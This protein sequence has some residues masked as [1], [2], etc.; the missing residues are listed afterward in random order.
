MNKLK[1]IKI[2]RFVLIIT[3]LVITIPNISSQ[4]TKNELSINGGVGLSAFIMQPTLENVLPN[5]IIGDIGFGLTF[6]L[7]PKWGI[8]LGAGIG[9]AQP[10]AKTNK[11]T[12]LNSGLTDS[13][14]YLF[15]LH[16]NLLYFTEQQSMSFLSVPLMLHY[17]AMPQ[18]RL[19]AQHRGRIN[20]FYA[21]TGIKFIIPQNSQYRSNTTSLTNAAYYPDMDNWAGTQ[22]FAGLGTFEGV[23]SEGDL[24]LDMFVAFSLEA[25]IK[26]I[27]NK[28]MFLYTGL[29]LDI[30]LEDPYQNRRL[31][32]TD[33]N[34]A[35][36][37]SETSFL[38]FSD[39]ITFTAVGLKLRLAFTS[40][41]KTQK[42][43]HWIY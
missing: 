35:V 43:D 36:L 11:I 5:G 15:D 27:I 29:F 26:S 39:K 7:H 21:M 24:E 8:Y 16:T 42:C 23:G 32:Y 31:S 1:K 33:Q 13:N 9:L 2:I 40:L 6:F 4:Q 38:N 12:I 41:K 30:G 3:A 19:S 10:V 22:T 17:Q 25:G 20:F 14:G 37:I 18:G 34:A 28:K